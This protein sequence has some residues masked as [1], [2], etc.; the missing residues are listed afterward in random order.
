MNNN[1][2]HVFMVYLLR[3]LSLRSLLY[4]DTLSNM[5]YRKIMSLHPLASRLFNNDIFI[6]YNKFSFSFISVKFIK[7]I[8]MLISNLQYVIVLY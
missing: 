4:P 8:G 5:A 2:P 7:A 1:T 3:T 6:N